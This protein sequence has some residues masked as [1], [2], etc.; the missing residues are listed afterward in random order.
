M[1]TASVSDF[2]ARAA[3]MASAITA[4]AA[5]RPVAPSACDTS[6][7]G[8]AAGRD[9][10]LNA[11]IADLKANPVTVT[12]EAALADLQSAGCGP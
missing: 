7:A 5:D 9:R 6:E 8:T 1:E 11:Q 10:G 2:Q 3:P 4:K 12:D